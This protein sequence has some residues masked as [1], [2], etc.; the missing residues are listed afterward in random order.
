[1]IR[2]SVIVD[3]SQRIL[4][5]QNKYMKTKLPAQE[6]YV[7]NLHRHYDIFKKD[8]KKVIAWAKSEIKEYQRLIKLL[9]N[10]KK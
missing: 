8:P 6:W 10:K 4:V 1:M 3:Q 7:T 5:K 2:A 9:E